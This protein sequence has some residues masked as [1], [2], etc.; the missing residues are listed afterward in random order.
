MLRDQ[1]VLRV[2]LLVEDSDLQREIAKDFLKDLG[3]GVVMEAK[4]GVEALQHLQKGK[5]DLILSD[6]Q[7]PEMDGLELLKQVKANPSYKD[8]PFIILTVVDEKDQIVQAVKEGVTDYIIKP[9]E[10]HIL[11]VKL[12]KLF[13]P[14]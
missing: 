5:I 12:K 13:D 2:V 8:I 3:F 7:M 4:D 11:K 10:R 14:A 1:L 6:W 9:V